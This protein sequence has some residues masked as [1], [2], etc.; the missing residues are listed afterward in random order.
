MAGHDLKLSCILA[1]AVKRGV[2][3]NNSLTVVLPP[4]LTA[5]LNFHTSHPAHLKGSRCPAAGILAALLHLHVSCLQ[6][7]LPLLQP[8][9][10]APAALSNPVTSHFQR[11]L[12]GGP[13]LSCCSCLDLQILTAKCLGRRM[14]QQCGKNFNVADIMLPASDTQPE[15]R[16]PPL[17]PPAACMDKMATRSDD[18]LDV[19]NNRLEV[20]V[21]RC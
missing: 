21:M 19:I 18:T 14:C 7:A 20:S 10:S 9:R 2:T 17:N 12:D 16:M 6:A 15:I 3:L 5:H 11:L 13:A 8:V 4:W 1:G